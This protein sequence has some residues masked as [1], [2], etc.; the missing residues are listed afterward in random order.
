MIRVYFCNNSLTY[1]SYPTPAQPASVDTLHGNPGPSAPARAAFRKVRA[2]A[3]WTNS[4]WNFGTGTK[5]GSGSETSARAR[6][7]EY[8]FDE[9]PARV[10]RPSNGLP[11]DH[12]VYP[13]RK[14]PWRRALALRLGQH[15]R[16]LPRRAV[17]HGPLP[18]DVL[19]PEFADRV[20]KRLF[21]SERNDRR[22]AAARHPSLH[23]VGD[24]CIA[25]AAPDAGGHR[26]RL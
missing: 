12:R 6:R 13:V 2:R 25:R 15:A 8:R 16:L 20:G 23:R 19:Q 4:R 26:R 14:H 22:L 10:A 11:A 21:Y 7:K 18:L 3:A 24:E 9:S 5:S 1:P 17:P